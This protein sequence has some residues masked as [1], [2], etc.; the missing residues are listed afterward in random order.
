MRN[1]VHLY[2]YFL[3]FTI[4]GYSGKQQV[5]AQ[6]DAQLTQYMYNGLFFNPSF[7]GKESGYRFTALHRSQWQGY[8]TSTG[9]GGA[10]T[11]Q[12][13]TTSGR[14]PG[15]D[16]GL[17]LTFA[18]DDIGP[19]S[20]QEANLSFAYHRLVGRGTLSIGVSGGF[21][22]STIKFDE[23]DVVNP[24]PIIPTTGNESRMNINF[25]AG[26]MYENTK[27][28]V[29]LSSKHLNEPVFDFGDGSVDNQLNNHSYLIAGYKIKTFA[30][31][32]FNPSLLVKSVSLNNFSYDFSVIATHNNKISGGLAYRGEE[33]VSLLLGYHLLRDNSL[34]LGYAFDLVIGGNEAKAPSSHEFMLTY[35]LPTISRKIQR[36]IQRTPR[37]R[38]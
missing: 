11:T 4:I 21:F 1:K 28:Y 17:G 15:T 24:D 12:V 36:V 31:L 3:F 19:S 10:P 22:S 20:N 8:S 32:V 37:F 38:F 25:G 30:Q 14:I 35:N 29:G 9:Q 16:F 2:F 7:S 23:I 26:I 5:A 13:L 34:R 27:Y 6:Q 18:N 33:S